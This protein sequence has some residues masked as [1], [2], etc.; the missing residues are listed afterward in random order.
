[1]LDAGHRRRDRLELA[2]DLVGSGGLHV[3]GVELARP[4]VQQEQDTGAGGRPRRVDSAACNRPGSDS[5]K[6][7]SPPR[8]SQWRRLQVFSGTGSISDL[9][10]REGKRSGGKSQ[11]PERRMSTAFC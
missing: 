4:A 2:A 5:P 8:R 6:A 11:K 7:P 10:F 1:M 3:P 9:P